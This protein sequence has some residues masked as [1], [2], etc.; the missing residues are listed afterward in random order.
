MIVHIK[1]VINKIFGYVLFMD[2]NDHHIG[3]INILICAYHEW[4]ISQK[5]YMWSSLI[6]CLVW[7]LLVGP[8]CSLRRLAWGTVWFS[9]LISPPSRP[10]ILSKM[11]FSSNDIENLWS[12]AAFNMMYKSCGYGCIA[13]GYSFCSSLVSSYFLVAGFS[14]FSSNI[15]TILTGLFFVLWQ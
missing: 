2:S 14:L 15:F 1:N 3:G 12:I 6:S 11:T 7:L 10:K 13:M 4:Y 5:S 9:P 8:R